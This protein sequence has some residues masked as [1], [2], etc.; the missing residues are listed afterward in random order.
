[1]VL[2]RQA[3]CVRITVMETGN[4]SG[5]PRIN[6]NQAKSRAEDPEPMPVRL[7]NAKILAFPEVSK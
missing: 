6:A 1:M 4:A 5:N 3:K 7:L 2:A